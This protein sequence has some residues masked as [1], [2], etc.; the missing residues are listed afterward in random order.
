MRSENIADELKF[1][2]K[3]R[4]FKNLCNKK[5]RDNLYNDDDPE[6]I[7]KKFWTHRKSKTTSHR[8]PETM[9]R[10]NTYRNKSVD[11][12]ELFNDFFCDQ[13]SDP[14]NYDIDI[15]FVNDA[16]INNIDFNISRIQSLLANLY[17]YQQG[18]WSR[19]H[20]WESVKVLFKK[21]STSTFNSF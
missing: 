20:T 13:F 16:T 10:N 1:S 21:F 15:D 4:C 9:H 2:D 14:S 8:I 7:T 11:K 6:L 18:L 5:T 19:S 3:R 12:A 17:K